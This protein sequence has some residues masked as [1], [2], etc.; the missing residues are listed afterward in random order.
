MPLFHSFEF[1]G[2]HSFNF[3]LLLPSAGRVGEGLLFAQLTLSQC[4]LNLHYHSPNIFIEC[5]IAKPNDSESAWAASLQRMQLKQE[6]AEIAKEQRI[7]DT[8]SVT[9]AC[10]CLN[11]PNNGCADGVG[12]VAELGG[13][14]SVVDPCSG[15][16]MKPPPSSSSTPPARG[17]EPDGN[18]DWL[19]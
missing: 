6:I 1:A 13:A 3:V 8:L 11:V 5:L 19:A 14:R 15:V 7:S 16:I 9:S 2:H 12:I 18:C 10:S 17:R 4:P